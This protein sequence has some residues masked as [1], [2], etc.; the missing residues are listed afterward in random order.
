ME[1]M[2]VDG[3]MYRRKR[4]AWIGEIAELVGFAFFAAL[5]IALMLIGAFQVA[6]WNGVV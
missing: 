2:I 6:R 5:G 1:K 4:T 3:A